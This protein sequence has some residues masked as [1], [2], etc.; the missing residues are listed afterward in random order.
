MQFGVQTATQNTTPSE[1]LDTWRRL[2]AAGYD[3]ISIWDHFYAVGGGTSNLE[4]VSMHTAL[5]METS[6]VRCGSLVYSAGYRS[7]A[8]LV[9][10]ITTIDHLSGGRATL[11]L[12]TGYMQHE[13]DSWGLPFDSVADRLD[14][15][16]ETIVA[17]RRLL[18]G[19]TVTSSGRF[20]NLDQAVCDPA[21]VQQHLPIWVGGGGEGRTIP[22]AARLADGW[23][24]PMATLEDYGRKVQVLDDHLERAG[25]AHDAIE[26]SVGLGLCFDRDQLAE[27][28]GDRA[29]TIAPAVLSGSTEEVIDRVAAYGAAGA[30][31]VFVSTRAPFDNE[32]LER[33]AAEVIPA[34]T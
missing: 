4:A 17:A 6:R 3:W 23:N 13:Y 12:G 15:L 21:P 1:L 5:A 29:A 7:L 20:V 11:G 24:V 27:R 9:N 18:D 22:M 19:E 2:E 33:F 16:E 8:V 10:A 28:Y 34:V 26:R 32:E 31:W 14:R 30:D 25:R